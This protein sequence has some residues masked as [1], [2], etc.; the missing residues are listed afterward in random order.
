MFI[1]YCFGLWHP[2]LAD[3]CNS[4]LSLDDNS[5][6]VTADSWSLV[7]RHPA[8]QFHLGARP[9]TE[10]RFFHEQMPFLGHKEGDMEH[11]WLPGDYFTRR[12]SVAVLLCSNVEPAPVFASQTVTCFLC[13]RWERKALRSLLSV[14]VTT[15]LSSG[16]PSLWCQ[17]RWTFL[18]QQS[19]LPRCPRTTWCWHCCALSS[20]STWLL[21]CGRAMPTAGHAL[22][23]VP[24]DSTDTAAFFYVFFFYHALPG[25]S[26]EWKVNVTENSAT[27]KTSG[28]IR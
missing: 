1:I 8:L 6:D 3:F 7:C 5:R 14:C 26:P 18:A 12:K 10:H 27:R 23:S 19:C 21:C 11:W 17:T 13:H 22:R 20:A 9:E 15:S 16:A 24:S 28:H 25:F 2:L 4:R